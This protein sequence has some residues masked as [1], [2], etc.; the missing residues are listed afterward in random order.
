MFWKEARVLDNSYF[1]CS[2]KKMGSTL[3]QNQN[4]ENYEILYEVEYIGSFWVI[5]PKEKHVGQETDFKARLVAGIFEEME[6][7]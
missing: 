4:L 6:K 5:T 7:P 2:I 3:F 1:P